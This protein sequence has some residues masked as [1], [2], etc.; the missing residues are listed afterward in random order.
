MPVTIPEHLHNEGIAP[1][2]VR[3][4]DE[5]R[6][7]GVLVQMGWD[8][9]EAASV[10]LSGPHPMCPVLGPHRDGGEHWAVCAP[11]QG[12]ARFYRVDF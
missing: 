2:W 8:E 10:A 4:T 12:V 11:E 7:R 5:T 3:A 9:Q 6:A 1:E